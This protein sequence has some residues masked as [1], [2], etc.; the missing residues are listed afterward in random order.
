MRYDGS[1]AYVERGA[2][3]IEFTLDDRRWH[4][5]LQAEWDWNR[6]P[7]SDYECTGRDLTPDDRQG[8]ARA[9]TA[10]SSSPDGRWEA[11]VVNHNVVVS[12]LTTSAAARVA[13]NCTGT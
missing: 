6:V 10:P 13:P 1:N 5:E 2:M 4:C 8:S 3:V 11:A 12:P 7:P 9:A